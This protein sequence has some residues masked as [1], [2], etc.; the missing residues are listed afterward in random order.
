MPGSF[1][2]FHN[3]VTY[4]T[5]P[6][7]TRISGEWPTGRGARGKQG[8]SV[9]LALGFLAPLSESQ[10]HSFRQGP[11]GRGRAWK[12]GARDSSLSR[13][14]CNSGCNSGWLIYLCNTNWRTCLDNSDLSKQTLCNAFK[15]PG[16]I[17][18]SCFR[19]NS[20]PS[21]PNSRHCSWISK[22]LFPFQMTFFK[23]M[24]IIKKFRSKCPNSKIKP[25]W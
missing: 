3:W 6:L 16:A 2:D 12:W 1:S 13:E 9:L 23:R 18:H 21:V 15:V 24:H 25:R 14:W 5:P 10:H 17:I 8:R 4:C 19:N 20:H 22:F 11:W 7:W